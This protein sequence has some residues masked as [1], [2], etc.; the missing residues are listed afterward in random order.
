[1]ALLCTAVIA[2]PSEKHDHNHNG[3]ESDGPKLE[4]WENAVFYQIYP[5]SFKDSDGDGIGDIKGIIEQLDYLQNLGV[6]GAWLSPIFKV[7]LF[8]RRKKARYGMSRS[9]NYSF[10]I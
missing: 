2:L 1:M 8:S 10:S 9:L 3:T 7:I 5:R 6:D 4:W